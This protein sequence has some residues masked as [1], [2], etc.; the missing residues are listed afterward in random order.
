[1]KLIKGI[2]WGLL[3]G[4]M[5]NVCEAAVRSDIDR[6]IPALIEVES[7]GNCVYGDGGR[8][9]GILQIH[10]AIIKDVNRLYGTSY[11]LADRAD[12]EKSK[13]I[14]RL[15]LS[16]WGKHYEKTNHK[17]ATLELYARLWNGGSHGYTKNSTIAYWHRV[18][19]VLD[20]QGS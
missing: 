9:Y 6:L 12:A 18:K 3:A 10:A 20:R 13:Q 7:G 16:Y 19:R 8:A 5:S 15:Y 17:T 1:M 2:A 14:C 4:L 11:V